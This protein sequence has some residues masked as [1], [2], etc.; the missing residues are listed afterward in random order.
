MLSQ[1]YIFETRN[2][3]NGFHVFNICNFIINGQQESI[4]YIKTWIRKQNK[5]TYYRNL[6]NH[7]STFFRK[8]RAE[9]LINNST[10]EKSADLYS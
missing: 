1:L 7:Q 6:R 10:C 4:D 3:K 2:F 9:T 8:H 5:L